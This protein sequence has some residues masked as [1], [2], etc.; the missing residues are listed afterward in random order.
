MEHWYNFSIE[1]IEGEIWKDAFQY[2]GLYL[3]SNFSRIKAIKK[4]II[5][6]N[7]IHNG[8][9]KVVLSKC[10]KKKLKTIHRLLLMAFK[11]N[12]ENKP[13]INHLDGNKL[14]IRLS[15]LVWST[16]SENNQHA[17]DMGLKI[18]MP[19]F[20]KDH[21]NSKAIIQL[22]LNYGFVDEFE[23]GFEAKRKLGFNNKTISK[24][25][26]GQRKTAFG[27][28]WMYKTDYEKLILN[29]KLAS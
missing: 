22:D 23:C 10:G 2:E 14:N 3:V 4:N 29:Q 12:P 6:K 25:L 15:N 1:N 16:Y 17:Y 26:L 9:L 21:H 20:G 19:K 27:F 18:F 13:C 28:K 7:Y 11:D 24:A 8:Y 5:L